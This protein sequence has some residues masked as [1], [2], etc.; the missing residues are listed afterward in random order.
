MRENEFAH[1]LARRLI[2]A[3]TRFVQ[4]HWPA[5]ANGNPKVDAWDTHAENFA[6]L[7]NLHCPKLDSGLG[8]FACLS[9]V[10][11]AIDG[12]MPVLIDGG[13]RRGTDVFKALALGA[14]AICVG[15]PY[16]WGLAAYGEA[17]VARRLAVL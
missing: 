14:D 9:E 5:V 10:V 17:G 4:V 12:R 1:G 3:G 6:P 15:R 8:T 16:C 7:K 11:G 13:F 2:E